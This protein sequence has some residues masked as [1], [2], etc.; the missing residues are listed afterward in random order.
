MRKL[1][2]RGWSS[3]WAPSDPK[4]LT[5]IT[6]MLLPSPPSLPPPSRPTNIRT[7]TD[8]NHTILS[9]MAPSLEDKMKDT[10]AELRKTF[11]S[12]LTLPYKWREGQ[13][14]ALEAMVKGHKK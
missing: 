13:L 8:N 5:I 3:F 4:C 7:Q 2:G 12:G 10:V 14:K 9:I 6:P 11:E 1:P